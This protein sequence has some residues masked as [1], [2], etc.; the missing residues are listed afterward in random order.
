MIYMLSTRERYVSLTLSAIH[1]EYS[2]LKCKNY[3]AKDT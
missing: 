1:C 2:R 3:H